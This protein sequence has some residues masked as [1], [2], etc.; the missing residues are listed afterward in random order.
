MLIKSKLIKKYE[1]ITEKTPSGII[2]NKIKVNFK[3]LK[4]TLIFRTIAEIP[5]DEPLCEFI[6]EFGIPIFRKKG[7]NYHL[8]YVARIHLQRKL[9]ITRQ[10]FNKAEDKTVF[11]HGRE[12]LTK[13]EYTTQI[14]ATPQFS[15]SFRGSLPILYSL[16]DAIQ[17]L[18]KLQ[19]EAKR[20]DLIR[21]L[22][23]KIEELQKKI[24]KQQKEEIANL[25]S[26]LN[27]LDPICY[28]WIKEHPEVAIYKGKKVYGKFAG[29]VHLWENELWQMVIDIHIRI[30]T[31][32][33]L[34]IPK[35]ENTGLHHADRPYRRVYPHIATKGRLADKRF[36][37][38]DPRQKS[39]N[40]SSVK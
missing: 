24:N 31:I 39:I 27:Q 2:I 22:I 21:R 10:R 3:S 33:G 5:I 8:K 32:L 15:L 26:L 34:P 1:P 35:K 40:K 19:T 25:Q 23:I 6:E 12:V 17:V 30:R 28:D 37:H 16:G 7:L 29:Y 36:D 18:S 38:E 20:S 4:K 9:D 14:K 13:Q 11:I